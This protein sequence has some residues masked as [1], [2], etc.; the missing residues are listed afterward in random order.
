MDRN[1]PNHAATALSGP[2]DVLV[3]DGREYRLSLP[4]LT[5]AEIADAVDHYL[6]S[7]R[8]SPLEAL[9]M[10][11]DEIKKLQ[12]LDLQEVLV[13][14]AFAEVRRSKSRRMNPVEVAHWI[15]S[16]DGLVW[17]AWFAITRAYPDAKVTLDQVRAAVLTQ[18]TNRPDGT[19]TT[20]SDS[21]ATS[22]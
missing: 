2:I 12:R 11:L 7:Q 6:Q 3:I 15:Q 9:A 8:Y 16:F 10:S 19:S 21:T 20:T 4:S 5:A 17:L 14:Q 13:Q 18:L 1:T 22:A